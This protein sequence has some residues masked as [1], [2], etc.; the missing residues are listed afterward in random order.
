MQ[1][2][3]LAG[4]V[5][6]TKTVLAA[7]R[8]GTGNEAH[9]AEATF[10]NRRYSGLDAI[11]TE[12]IE[13]F[14][15]RIEWASLSVAGP[16][17][18]GQTVMSN[19]RWRINREQIRD[20]F[21]LA[22]VY[23]VN[24][25]QATAYA[26]PWLAPDRLS[27]LQPGEPR[28]D[29]PRAIIAPGTGLGEAYL[30]WDGSRFD[31]FP[32]EGGNADFAPADALQL[33]MLGYMQ[34]LV[35]HVSFEHFCSGLGIPNIYRFLKETG[36]AS[37][38][39]WLADRLAAAVDPAPIIVETALKPDGACAI[40]TQTMELFVAVLAAE[41]GNMALRLLASGGVYI[42]GGIPP[43]IL[44]FLENGW[45]MSAF[46]R[47]GRFSEHMASYPVHVILEP[48]AALLGAAR[49]AL[50]LPLATVP[51]PLPM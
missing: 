26:V 8:P 50:G 6:G 29:R 45:F 17:V 38:P 22:S 34:R 33:E 27:T 20:Q 9:V 1:N 5:G 51:S 2:L 10:E 32:S 3:V 44:P 48:R 31:A 21:R 12:F 35:G 11:I 46:R 39:P 14:G 4:D 47:K 42:G 40:C 49:Y 19:L 37:E 13:R 18:D 41:A 15:L 23:L 28:A 36:V 30:V 16:V 24:D 25:L 43:R 7:L